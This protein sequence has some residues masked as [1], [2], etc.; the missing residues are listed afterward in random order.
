MRDSGFTLLEV[1]IAFLIAALAL[2]VL[3]RSA[4]EGQTAANVGARYAEAL[5][6]ARSHLAATDAAGPP[7]AGDQGGDDGGG[8]HWRVRTTPLR[9]GRPG[10]GGFAPA[11]FAVSV[12]V[13][14]TADGR[15][16][17]VQLDTRRV[18]LAPPRPP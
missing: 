1:L 4:V 9:E 7:R 18:G 5:S 15:E 12:A 14:W 17:A 3:F 6:R 10:P 11:L 2:G 8:F 13:S 16:R